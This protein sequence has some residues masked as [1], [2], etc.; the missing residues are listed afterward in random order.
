M[1]RDALGEKLAKGQT[2]L[3]IWIHDPWTVE[4]AAHL[5]FD[6]FMIDQMFTSIDWPR[7]E[8][9]IRTGEA[10]GITPVVRVQSNPW[11][12]Y[13]PRIAVDVTRAAGIGAYHIFVSNSCKKEIE[14]CLLAAGDWHRKA[15]HIHP[16]SSSKEW[17]RGVGEIERDTY[18]IP[19]PESSGALDEIEETLALPGVRM[20]FIAMSDASRKLLGTAEP[21]W[22]HPRIWELV[23]RLVAQAKAKGAVIG[24]NTSYGYSMAE[25]ANRVVKLKEH[26]VKMIMVQGAHFLFQVAVG[27]FLKEVKARMAE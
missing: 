27:E 5:G 19:Q 6:W 14:D 13:D 7:T 21:D 20:M 4:L 24:A 23:D 3:G 8:E 16:F 2:A 25:M 11:I 15:L 17:D 22:Y 9:L 18:I 12:G 26:G 1:W 10:A